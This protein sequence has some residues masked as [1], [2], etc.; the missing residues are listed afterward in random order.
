ML[1]GS[2]AGAASLYSTSF[3]A[4]EGFTATEPL[5]GVNGW[6]LSNAGADTNPSAVVTAGEAADGSQFVR[7][8]NGAE[9]NRSFTDDQNI[10][11]QKDVIWVEGYFRG[12]G[13]DMSLADAIQSYQEGDASAIVHFSQ[14][15]GIEFYDGNG[16][17][18]GA[19]QQSAVT[20][21]DGNTWYKIT[22]RLNFQ[23]KSW[24]VWVKPSNGT[25]TSAMGLGFRDSSITELR[26]FKNLA[27]AQAD[28]DAFR[29]VSAVPGDANGDASIDSADVISLLENIASG[30]EDVIVMFNGDVNNDG[31][32][33]AADVDQLVNNLIDNN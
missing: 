26:G 1:A 32:V 15:N 18:G 19:V 4:S 25:S 23:E 29:V 28:F 27:Q 6:V 31:E 7:L 9:I 17:G 33:N 8:D 10:A 2:V 20:T 22:I 21:L 11:A 16:T 30:E 5:N 12:T 24:D 13:S 3:E 14:V